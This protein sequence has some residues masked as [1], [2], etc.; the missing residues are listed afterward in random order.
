MFGYT[1]DE[2]IG[3][4]VLDQI[5]PEDQA[6]AVE[7]WLA[8]LSSRRVQQMRCRRKRKDGSFMWIDTTLHNYLNQ[9]DRN[10]VLVEIIDVSAEMA[11]QEALQDQ[12]ALLRRLIEAMPDGLLQA[13]HRATRRLPQRSPAGDPARRIGF[14][15]SGS[16]V[17]RRI[18]G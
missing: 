18:R 12:G 15:I 4:R 14:S 9:P 17:A 10:Y 3:E 1:A 6:R 7:G 8:L 13:R 5:H 16:A 11:A 2:L